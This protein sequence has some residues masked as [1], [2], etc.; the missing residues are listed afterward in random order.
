MSAEEKWEAFKDCGDWYVGCGHTDDIGPL[1]E[2]EAKVVARLLNE[3]EKYRAALEAAHR[4]LKQRVD[5]LDDAE[6]VD[7]I[8]EA[9]K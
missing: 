4:Q 7:I 1:C 6:A 2:T 5:A 8:E 9:L 3:R